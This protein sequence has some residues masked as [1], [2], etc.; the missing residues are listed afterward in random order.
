MG[1]YLVKS[2]NEK[3]FEFTKCETFPVVFHDPMLSLAC[4]GTP[5]SVTKDVM[6]GQR[7]LPSAGVTWRTKTPKQ[8][9]GHGTDIAA[10]VVKALEASLSIRR[11]IKTALS[12]RRAAVRAS[13]GRSE[14]IATDLENR[15]SG[16]ISPPWMTQAKPP[17]RPRPNAARSCLRSRNV[18][19]Q[20]RTHAARRPSPRPY[21]RSWAGEMDRNP[22]ATA[23][24]KRKASR[25]ISDREG[26]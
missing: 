16:R 1:G 26:A 9:G 25:S 19:W 22:S 2:L 24:G 21:P 11:S 8:Q 23:I 20:R 15:P 13:R 17:Q 6:K 12:K 14:D 7:A 5:K 3:H 10:D 18:H 4:L